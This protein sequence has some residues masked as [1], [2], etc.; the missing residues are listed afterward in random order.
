MDE[1]MAGPEA[2]GERAVAAVLERLPSPVR[3]AFKISARV[4]RG[5]VDRIVV[6][7]YNKDDADRG[8]GAS[9]AP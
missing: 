5:K 2:V 3:E 4:R 6:E 7:R 1:S 8:R 9:G